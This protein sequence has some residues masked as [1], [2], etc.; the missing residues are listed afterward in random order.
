MAVPHDTSVRIRE[1]WRCNA[2]AEF[3]LIGGLKQE[4]STIVID[5]EFPESLKLDFLCSEQDSNEDSTY[6]TLKAN[7]NMMKLIQV[8]STLVD[9]WGRL[10][11]I[12]GAYCVWQFNL[13][14][15][16]MKN[17]IF[18]KA[19]IQLLQN[20]GIDF[21]RNRRDGLESRT[22]GSLLLKHHL[23][24]NP[25]M[26]YVCYQGD[27]DLAY[28][29]KAVTGDQ[30]LPSSLAEY[31]YS[32]ISMFGRIFDVRCAQL[33]KFS[34]SLGVKRISGTS[35]QAGSDSL[36]TAS[37]YQAIKSLSTSFYNRHYS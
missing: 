23:V 31:T 14:D 32:K 36:L 10:P 29:H 26:H 7:V 3:K 16:D 19:S 22:L 35:H 28:L 30:Q 21:E 13:C 34:D 27:Y 6:R 5:T 18:V 33:Q 15:F 20:S 12:E 25:R 11:M 4:F 8:G 1:V 9:N 17:D 2:A 24:F 37:T